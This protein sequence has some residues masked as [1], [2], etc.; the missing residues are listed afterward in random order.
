[1]NTAATAAGVLTEEF[2][3]A[4]YV[5]V[6]DVMAK[7]AESAGLPTGGDPRR[8]FWALDSYDVVNGGA[9]RGATKDAQTAK[10]WA[11]ALGLELDAGVWVG[12]VDT[13]SGLPWAVKLRVRRAS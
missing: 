6:R 1:M 13:G 8:V 2:Q 3:Y 11:D 9:L 12:T 4:L 10:A 7:V 5:A